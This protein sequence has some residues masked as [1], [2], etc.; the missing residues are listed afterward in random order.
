[1]G[2]QYALFDDSPRSS[3]DVPG[4][5]HLAG[6]E[7]ISRIIGRT[8]A[9]KLV[10][11]FAQDL[12]QRDAE[13]TALR[14]R[15]DNR[16]RELKRFLRE[17]GVPSADIEKRLLRLEQSA[18][19]FGGLQGSESPA[20]SKQKGVIGG[21]LDEAMGQELPGEVEPELSLSFSGLNKD[22]DPSATGPVHNQQDSS[23]G[24][25]PG[26]IIS[27][28][29]SSRN[30]SASQNELADANATIKPRSASEKLGRIRGLEGL[31]QPTAQ[32]TS[33]FIGGA[34][35]T[36]R[37]PKAVDEVSVRSN[38]SSS[39]FASWTKLFGGSSQAR[40][41]ETGRARSSSLEQDAVDDP[42]KMGPGPS[43]LSQVRTDPSN[44]T[45]RSTSSIPSTGTVREHPT[46]R[47]TPTATRLSASPGHARKESNAS[48]FPPTV[49]MDSMI[50]SSQ[51]PP[52]MTSH[53]QDIE[54][55]L[56][57]RFGFIYDQRQRKRQAAAVLQHKRNRLSTAETLASLRN[58]RSDDEFGSVEDGK[59]IRRPA[60]PLSIDEDVPKKSWQDYLKVSSGVNLGRPR[61]LLSHAPSAG[62]VVTVNTADASGTITPPSRA[63]ATSISI[64]ATASRAL[65]SASQPSQPQQSDVN[66]SSGDFIPQIQEPENDAS[67]EK[68]PVRLLLEQLNELHDTLQAERAVKWNE[69]LRKV[70]AERASLAEKGSNNTPEADLLHGELIG[71]ASLGRSNKTR[72]KYL[73]F[74]SL[75]L[76]GITTTLRPK[77]WSECAGAS[78]LRI[79][80]YYDDLVARSEEGADIDPDIAMQIKADI[81][82]T[83]PD[84]TFFRHGPGVPK[85]EELLRAYS[86]HNPRIGY[87]Q[88]MNLIT[89]SLL[90]ICPTSEECFWLLVAIVDHILPSGYFDRSL[91]V[92]RADQIVLRSYV[93]EVLPKLDAKL[94]ELGV[95]LEACTFHWF[96]S[97]YAGVL[98]GGEAL[99]RI[100]D[101]VLCLNSSDVPNIF[102]E[103]SQSLTTEVR[104]WVSQPST[105]ITPSGAEWSADPDLQT[106]EHDGTSSPFLFQLGLALLKL[107]ETAILSLESPAQVYSYINHNMTNHAIS[108]D[109][110]VQAAEA[111]R[112]RVKRAE[113]LERRRHA[114]AELIAPPPRIID[115]VATTSADTS[116]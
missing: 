78:T 102:N 99:Y 10:R 108:I 103:N 44:A 72:A 90:L 114:I 9:V 67:M 98:T 112:A 18:D 113:V 37:K 79:P 77:I 28:R 47:R 24:D 40:K 29:K 43:R 51:L 55:L 26:S 49:E 53:N 42:V 48:D 45:S 12:A 81:R 110:L 21:L 73:Q 32:S 35:K 86:L 75:V 39:S 30:N 56:T 91:L 19:P 70:R 23:S 66:V 1:M 76:H 87:C 58:E 80:G 22:L 93:S 97:L 96:L 33:Y 88:G 111:L 69:F 82:R 115:A 14:I 100:W 61:E 57:D 116:S 64:F 50:E 7:H 2:Q 13:L 34:S 71:I 105:P 63:R 5:L 107:N 4:S 54:G 6:D 106:E 101:C 65:P 15:A 68:E 84:N 46:G 95:E 85:L 104:G 17:A 11:Q 59:A 20:S 31:F 27:S 16:E 36:V 83:L 62:A 60:T 8:G 25:Q 74:K 38:Q 41:E 92:S 89:A 3:T 94:Q 109:G 52:T